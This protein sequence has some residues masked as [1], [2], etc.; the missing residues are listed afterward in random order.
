VKL[1]LDSHAYLWWLADDQRLGAKAK[2]AITDPANAVLVSAATIWEIA[3]KAALGRLDLHGADVVAEIAINR[4][5][6]L[7]I[8]AAHAAA[9]A[10]LPRHHDDPFDRM[11]I[12][13]A[14][15]EHLRCVTRDPAFSAYRVPTLW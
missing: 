1:L 2:K 10:A 4:F 13:Q 7:P 11:L 12:A 9:A 3:I 8:T 6:E 5:V 15:L 14:Q